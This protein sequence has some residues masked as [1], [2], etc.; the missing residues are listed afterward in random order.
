MKNFKKNYFEITCISVLFAS[1]IATPWVNTDSLIIPKL[2][3]IFCTALY[4]FPQVIVARKKLSSTRFSKIFY[5]LI[6]LF[7]IQL[8]FVLVAS[9][10]PIEQQF[11]GRGGRGLGFA[12]EFSLLIILLI[13]FIYS[14]REKSKFILSTL[15]ISCSISTVYSV[16]QRFNLDIFE[17]NTRTNGI[18]GTLGNPNFQSSFA[19]MALIPAATLLYNKKFGYIYSVV[20]VTPLIGVVYISQSTQ[21]YILIATSL[22]AF[23]S[24]YFWYRVKIISILLILTSVIGGVVTVLGMINKGPLSPI[25]YKISVQSRSEMYDTA[26]R[27]VGDNSFFGV[28]LD[29][30][31]DYYF[32]YRTEA[33]AKGIGEYVDNVHNVFLNYAANGG[34]PL[35]LIYFLITLLTLYSFYTI[36]KKIKK[37]DLTITALFCAWLNYQIQSLISPTNIAMAAWNAVISGAAIGIANSNES[38]KE[39]LFNLRKK[40][41]LVKPF[42]Y[43]M[44]IIGLIL[45]YP[46]YKVDQEQ[47]KSAKTGDALLAIKSAKSFPESTVRYTRIGQ[48]LLNSKLEPQALEI[49]RAAVAFN[50]NSL[51]GWS[52]ILINNSAPR[53]DRINAYEELIRLDPHNQNLKNVSIP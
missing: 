36:Q 5:Y 4:M 26:I 46:Y 24:L 50:P 41:T 13:S 39:F 47:L 22:L 21:G 12:F 34:I 16:L 11:Y 1:I 49:G 15:V 31:G 52:L 44:L 40:S 25:L 19:A 53:S 17:W 29:S 10:A 45:V 6:I 14:E 20:L 38:N 32:M 33:S 51:S 3:I 18:I 9:D 27:I 30:L 7:I 23:L 2:I 37:F 28:G 8:I 48:E 43:L 35:A 42:G